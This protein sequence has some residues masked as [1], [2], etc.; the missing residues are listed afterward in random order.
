MEIN[1][2]SGHVVDAAIRVHTDLGP[3]LLESA[4]VSF[5]SVQLR[6]RGLR[7]AHE[8]PISVTYEGVE[9]H[10]GY[11]IDLLVQDRVVVEL[12]AVKRLLPVHEAQLLSYL[13]LGHFNVGLLINFHELHLRDGIKRVVS[14]Y[15]GS[16][17][18]APPRPPR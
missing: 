9:V 2:V 1:E 16:A 7:I 18:S 11:R 17:P 8:V 6:K 15:T 14:R 10:N 13:R 5:L 12:K 3:G 4:Y